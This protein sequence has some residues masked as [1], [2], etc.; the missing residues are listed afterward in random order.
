M[1]YF[2]FNN[3]LCVVFT[4]CFSLLIIFFFM[5][6]FLCNSPSCYG[7]GSV[8]QAGLDIIGLLPLPTAWIKGMYHRLA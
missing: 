7:T 4:V 3:K 5:T 2:N 8:N 1:I 6:G